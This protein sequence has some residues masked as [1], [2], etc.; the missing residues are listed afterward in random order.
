MTI[1]QS[2]AKT[3]YVMILQKPTHHRNCIK[4]KRKAFWKCADICCPDS[5][6]D[7]HDDVRQFFMSQQRAP[8]TKY[9]H[10]NKL[11]CSS[12][13]FHRV[14]GHCSS[15][16][17][18]EHCHKAANLTKELTSSRYDYDRCAGCI[19]HQK[20]MCEIVDFISSRQRE[21]LSG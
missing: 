15:G 17:D 18:D 4:Q 11:D 2:H 16:L 21:L 6:H 14:V 5:I 20:D 7:D 8:S 12:M 1:Y 13:L 9:M 10:V 3:R 19:L